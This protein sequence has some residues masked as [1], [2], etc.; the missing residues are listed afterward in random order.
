MKKVAIG[1]LIAMILTVG[2]FAGIEDTWDTLLKKHTVVGVKN[3][4]KLTLIDYKGIKADPKWPKLLAELGKAIPFAEVDAITT[5]TPIPTKNKELA[6]WINA[7]NI[8]AVKMMVDNYPLKSIKDKS[9]WFGSVW[10][11]KI[12]TVNDTV[13]SLGH[14][15]HQ[16]LRKMHEPQVHAAI[17][18][19]SVSCPDLRQEAFR[20]ATMYKQFHSQ[21]ANFLNNPDKGFRID[22]QKK[23]LYLSAIFKWFEGDFDNV[24]KFVAYYL[25]DNKKEIMDEKYQIRYLDYDWTSNEIIKEK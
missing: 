1:F 24:R 6:F 9:G 12:V 23:I 14:I 7:Y 18:C 13:Y 3:K 2:A 16:I 4:V 17:V 8:G 25:P 5:A 11:Q 15:E 21:W 22:K 20:S 10:D 19:A